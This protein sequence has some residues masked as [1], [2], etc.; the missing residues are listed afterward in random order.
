V[1]RILI[2]PRN[3]PDIEYPRCP[4]CGLDM[5]LIRIAPQS[6]SREAR[7]YGCAVCESFVSDGSAAIKDPIELL[8]EGAEERQRLAAVDSLASTN[9]GHDASK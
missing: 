5:W 9:G 2:T 4:S 3:W 7:I 6:A 8:N 1:S